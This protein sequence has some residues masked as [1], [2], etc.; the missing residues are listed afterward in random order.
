MRIQDVSCN[1]KKDF[2]HLFINVSV[3]KGGAYYNHCLHCDL[4]SLPTLLLTKNAASFSHSY[5]LYW[6]FSDHAY[7]CYADLN[8]GRQWRSKIIIIHNISDILSQWVWDNCTDT[9]WSSCHCGKRYWSDLYDLTFKS[10]FQNVHSLV[11]LM[12]ILQQWDD[13]YKCHH[14]HILLHLGGCTT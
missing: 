7:R 3:M 5:Q 12:E 11:D 1:D 8:L 13:S 14:S 6:R 10:L 4:D 9:Y 2:Y